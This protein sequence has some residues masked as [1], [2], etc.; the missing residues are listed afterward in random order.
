MATAANTFSVDSSAPSFHASRTAGALGDFAASSHRSET[1][2]ARGR[3]KLVAIKLVTASKEHLEKHYAD[4]KDKPFFPG[5]IT[6]TRH[7]LSQPIRRD[8]TH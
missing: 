3:Y 4:L 2:T 7:T 1:L 8:H 6:C 5:L